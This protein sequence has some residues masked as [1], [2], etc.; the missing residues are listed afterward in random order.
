[1]YRL[2][3]ALFMTASLGAFAAGEP[4]FSLVIENN[5][6]TPDRL[7]VPAGKKVKLVIENKDASSEEFESLEL[8]V[9]KVIPGKSKGVVFIGPLKAGEYRFVGEFHEKT[10]KGVV[11]AK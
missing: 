7:E 2:A 9:E 5:R 6:F 3:A 8:H 4:E 10:A 11:V 1:M